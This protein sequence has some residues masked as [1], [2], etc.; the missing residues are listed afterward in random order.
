MDQP[1]SDILIDR[2]LEAIET[3]L[4]RKMDSPRSFEEL[5]TLVFDRLNVLISVSTLKRLWGYVDT[6]A[7]P[8]RSTLSVLSRLL[9]YADWDGFCRA[10][11]N[12]DEVQSNPVITTRIDVDRDLRV[13]DRIRIMWQPGRICDVEYLGDGGFVILHAEQTRLSE[14]D[15]F[16][17][18][19]IIEHEP[20][21]IFHN[22][23]K[24]A[25]VC[26]KSS[27]VVIH[28]L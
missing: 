9:G 10:Y 8:R 17:C 1:N 20:M 13:G 7:V 23:L 19:L 6:D 4:G 22:G 3:A 25:Y 2:L 18:H 11:A 26:G 28:K 14:G 5:R 12:P 24:S 27:G 21:Y 16:E 15:T